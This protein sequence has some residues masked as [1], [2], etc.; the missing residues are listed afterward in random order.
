LHFRSH[1]LHHRGVCPAAEKPCS[2]LQSFTLLLLLLL[3][4]LLGVGAT[5]LLT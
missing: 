2:S 5:A 1:A 4:L 3:L